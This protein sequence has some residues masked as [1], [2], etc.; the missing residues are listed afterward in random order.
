MSEIN[1]IDPTIRKNTE[2]KELSIQISLNGFSYCVCTANDKNVIAFRSYQYNNAIL[3]EDVLSQTEAIIEQD[4]L[5]SMPFTKTRLLYISRKSTL[6]PDEY[7]DPDLIKRYIDFN[8]PIDDLDE[9]HFNNI[10][11]IKSNLVFA[12][13][14]Y[15]A[16]FI[17]D[18]FK[19]IEEEKSMFNCL[20]TN[21][22]KYTR[23]LELV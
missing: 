5:L 7:F 13:P 16:T 20:Q 2:D 1:L 22:I 21:R 17:T 19:N 14:T 4:S 23:S 18:K 9:L 12:I 15:L 6:V 11:R 10:Y 3:F 8:Q